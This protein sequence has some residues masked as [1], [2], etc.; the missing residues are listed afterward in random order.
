VYQNDRERLS[1]RWARR[2]AAALVSAFCLIAAIAVGASPA[3]AA[4]APAQPVLAS[5]ATYNFGTVRVA[6][7]TASV[8]FDIYNVGGAAS[9][10]LSVLI[11][12]ANGGSEFYDDSDTC[13]G[14]ALAGNQ[15]CTVSVHFRPAVLGAR[16][17]VLSIS[18]NPGGTVQVAL[19]GTGGTAALA[20]GATPSF[21]ATQVGA[22]SAEETFTFVNNGVDTSGPVSL[23]FGGA[24][25]ADFTKTSTTCG[26][27]TPVGGQCAVSM[28]FTR[29]RR[30]TASSNKETVP[31]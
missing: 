8:S 4:L 26:P 19:S 3:S 6:T 22:T 27:A 13:R 21:D 18:S 24:N 5:S 9:G 15:K 7:A 14:V 25:T 31:R 16:S 12:G 29:A 10:P 11:Q 17:A 20:L 23:A 28:V 1:S 30:A 2:S